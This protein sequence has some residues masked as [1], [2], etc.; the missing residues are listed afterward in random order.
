[1]EVYFEQIEMLVL[2]SNLPPEE[3]HE[4]LEVLASLDNDT[5]QEVLELFQK[6]ATWIEVVYQNFLDKRDAF[7][8]N[9]TEAILDILQSEETLLAQLDGVE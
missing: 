8:N 6:N 1:M 4:L 9:D 3:R 7:A 2:N 5:L